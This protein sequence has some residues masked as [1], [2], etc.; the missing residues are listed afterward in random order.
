[1]ISLIDFMP[2][3]PCSM[4]AVVTAARLRANMVAKAERLRAEAEAL[5]EEAEC[6]DSEADDLESREP[7]GP[8]S[9]P[10]LL[11][12]GG[13]MIEHLRLAPIEVA[14]I[15]RGIETGDYALLAGVALLNGVALPCVFYPR[16]A[17][18]DA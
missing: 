1:M 7:D 3:L 2:D 5:R 4:Q 18:G 16:V 14:R 11:L 15:E 17:K 8:E 10:T 6:L 12:V 9:E 13:W